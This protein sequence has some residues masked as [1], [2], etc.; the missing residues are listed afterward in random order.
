MAGARRPPPIA[1]AV[2]GRRRGLC[3][4]AKLLNSL[5]FRQLTHPSKKPRD[6]SSDRDGAP[7]HGATGSLPSSAG[8]APGRN[9]EGVRGRQRWSSV[10]PQ[11]ASKHKR[12]ACSMQYAAQRKPPNCL[13]PASIPHTAPRCVHSVRGVPRAPSGN[14]SRMDQP[15]GAGRDVADVRPLPPAASWIPRDKFEWQPRQR[16]VPVGLPRERTRRV[17]AEVE[18]R[19]VSSS[20][21]SAPGQRRLR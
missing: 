2:D 1:Q 21:V 6:P 19:G 14:W 18:P 5:V 10:T 17:S 12:A 3:R 8:G 20:Q 7:S 9:T 13:D 11:C 15:P 16:E 4:A